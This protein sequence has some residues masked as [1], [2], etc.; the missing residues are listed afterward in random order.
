MAGVAYHAGEVRKAED[1][2]GPK[3]ALCKG[4]RSALG[5]DSPVQIKVLFSGM[6]WWWWWRWWWDW[7]A[8]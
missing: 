2:E 4:Y 5:P 7:D 8:F 3:N 6:Q 1:E